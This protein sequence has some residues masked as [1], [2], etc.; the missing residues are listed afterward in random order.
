[1]R[2]IIACAGSGGHINPG[3][4]I[5]NEIL[6]RE[7]GSKIIFVGT[8]I[9]KAAA[10][11]QFLPHSDAPA[12]QQDTPPPPRR[13]DRHGGRL[14]HVRHGAAPIRRAARAGV[15]TGKIHRYFLNFLKKPFSE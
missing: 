2:A 13:N 3:I 6:K 1:M 9:G 14:R 12:A 10:F 15:N 8:K 11:E 5:A 4:A 7:P